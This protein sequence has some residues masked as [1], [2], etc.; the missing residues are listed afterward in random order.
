MSLVGSNLTGLPI[1]QAL[2]SPILP[3]QVVADRYVSSAVPA[4]VDTESRIQPR[5]K[6]LRRIVFSPYI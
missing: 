3:S 6:I 2:F 1:L 4:V 5:Q